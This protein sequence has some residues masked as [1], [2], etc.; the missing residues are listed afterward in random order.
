MSGDR[1]YTIFEL[2]SITGINR[3]TLKGW[4]KRGILP[5]SLGGRGPCAY[6]TNDHLRRIEQIKRDLYDSRVTI[7]DLRDRYD[8]L[9]D[10]GDIASYG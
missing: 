9:P 8:P 3:W 4:K 6:Y 10:E 5:P 1:G 2:A 7:A